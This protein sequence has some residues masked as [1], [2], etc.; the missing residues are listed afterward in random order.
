M[1]ET[2]GRV[3]RWAVGLSGGQAGGLSGGLS[4][5]W[6]VGLSCVWVGGPDFMERGVA[7]PVGCPTSGLHYRW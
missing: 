2:A 1:Q 5:G 6:A 4:G 7:L 3:G